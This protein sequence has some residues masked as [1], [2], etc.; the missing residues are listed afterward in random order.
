MPSIV[1]FHCCSQGWIRSLGSRARRKKLAARV[2]PTIRPI[3]PSRQ[4]IFSGQLFHIQTGLL[5]RRYCSLIWHSLDA[6]VAKRLQPPPACAKVPKFSRSGQ[7]QRVTRLGAIS[8][9]FEATWD[10][11]L[12]PFLVFF[13]ASYARDA[14]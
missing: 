1:Y 13:G 7:R 9:I 5:R 3:S 10:L 12:T 4:P 2:I 11:F 14:S 6:Q 8:A